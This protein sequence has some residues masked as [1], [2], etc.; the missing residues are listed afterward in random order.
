MTAK[1]LQITS[2][3]SRD[4]FVILELADN[5]G[6]AYEIKLNS[7]DVASLMG[8]VRAQ[9]DE[10]LEIG[11]NWAL[12]GMQRV[13]YLETGGKVFFRVFLSDH[14]FHEY[15]VPTNTTLSE[16][17]K[18]FADRIEARNAAKATHQLPDTGRKN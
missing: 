17:L 2:T 3:N 7:I 9:L 12:P 8:S 6:F 14:L 10:V 16:E 15:P 13:Q 18:Y 4:G 1:L 5:D 11:Q